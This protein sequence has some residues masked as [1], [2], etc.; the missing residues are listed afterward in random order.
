MP[1][2]K[3]VYEPIQRIEV[4]TGVQLRRRFS[5]EEKLRFVADSSQLGMSVSYIA[6]KHGIAPSML[7]HW[8][9]RLAKGGREAVRVDDE[10]IGAAEARRTE[11]ASA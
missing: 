10:V 9:R 6:H 8:R 5:L 4:F 1:V 2:A 3:P 7:F 11:G